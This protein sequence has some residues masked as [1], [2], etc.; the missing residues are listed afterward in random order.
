M[1]KKIIILILV[2]LFNG[3]FCNDDLQL[4]SIKIDN[5][6]SS[7]I[8]AIVKRDSHDS[9]KYTIESNNYHHYSVRGINSRKA[10]D[11]VDYIIIQNSSEEEIMDLRGEDL[12]NALILI[13]EGEF[14]PNYLLEVTE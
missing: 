3:C 4:M 10:S 14:G 13:G 9:N 12:D 2:F 8:Y 7:M 6:T 1:G 11:E 5:K